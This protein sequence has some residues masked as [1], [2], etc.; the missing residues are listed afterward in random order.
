MKNTHQ[1]SQLSV[2][3][4]VIAA[5]G[6]EIQL[7]RTLG[8]SQIESVQQASSWCGDWTPFGNIGNE[9]YDPVFSEAVDP[10]IPS[11]TKSKVGMK[12]NSKANL[13]YCSPDLKAFNRTSAYLA[14]DLRFKDKRRPEYTILSQSRSLADLLMETTPTLCQYTAGTWEAVFVLDASIDDSL[15]V[16][17][18]VLTSPMCLQSALVRARI[19]MEP[20]PGMLETSSLNLAMSAARPSHYYVH[21]PANVLIQDAGWNRDLAQPTLEYNDIFSV[22]GQCG[23]SLV[24]NSRNAA[25]YTVGRCTK[26]SQAEFVSDEDRRDTKHA[27]YATETNT[28]GLVLWRADAIRELGYLNEANFFERDNDEMNRR[29]YLLR[30]WYSA[31]KHVQSLTLDHEVIADEL[32][33][34]DGWMERHVWKYFHKDAN[35]DRDVASSSTSSHIIHLPESDQLA[36]SNYRRFRSKKPKVSCGSLADEASQTFHPYHAHA[37]KRRLT[38]DYNVNDPLPPLPAMI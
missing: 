5:I 32:D 19:Y 36:L 24:K 10:A 31:F 29:A 27:V 13:L 14:L 15:Q 4:F 16:L 3:V 20:L 9:S 2:S 26:E 6:L 12:Y 28:R 21:V 1:P 22:S 30:G 25:E 37:E 34:E 11:C 8:A 23:S 7:Q 35:L 38:M 18:E 17:H 33:D